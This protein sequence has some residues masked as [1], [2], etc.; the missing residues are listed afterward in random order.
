[1]VTQLIL[2]PKCRH[3]VPQEQL[4]ETLCGSLVYRET[5]SGKRRYRV[6]CTLCGH[7]R[8]VGLSTVMSLRMAQWLKKEES[9]K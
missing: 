5:K 3:R 2:V 9:K 8:E 6:K 7:I 1:M 4:P